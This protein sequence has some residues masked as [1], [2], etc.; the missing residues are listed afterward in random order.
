MPHPNRMNKSKNIFFLFIATCT[1]SS[2]VVTN[3]LYVN[4]P[5]PLGWGDGEAYIGVATGMNPKIDSVT[6]NTNVNFSNRMKYAPV[7]SI[8]GQVG[9]GKRMNL[10][11]GLH[12]PFIVGGL[13]ARLG[14]QY[15]LFE[16]DSPFNV[17]LGVNFDGTGANDSIELFGSNV[18]TSQKANGALNADVFLPISYDFKSGSTKSDE[19]LRL[20][21]TPRYSYNVLY[22]KKYTNE[23]SAKAYALFVPILSVG[24]RANRIYFES[25]AIYYNKSIYPHFGVAL[26]Y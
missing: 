25:S 14:A 24:V 23:K 5:T 11:A 17:A 4:D 10:K 9:V 7:L 8:G 22:I 13:G 16:S 15:S 21:I 6:N 26:M 12:F 19:V 20:I 3:N 18:P 1:F 2:C